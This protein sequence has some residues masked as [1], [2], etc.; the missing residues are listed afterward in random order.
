MGIK[1]CQHQ[2]K[3]MFQILIIRAENVQKNLQIT[4]YN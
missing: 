3:R 1:L 2:G 4:Y